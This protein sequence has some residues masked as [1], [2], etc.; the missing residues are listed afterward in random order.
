MKAKEHIGS[1][2]H[3]C[4]ADCR[5]ILPT[6][7]NESID[8]IITSPPYKK[9]DGAGPELFRPVFRECLR[10]LKNDG[11]CFVNIGH[12]REDKYSPH[13]FAMMMEML[14]WRLWENIH[15]WFK[16]DENGNQGHHTP[17]PGNSINNLH[18]Y[19]FMFYKGK[20]PELDRFHPDLGVKYADPGNTTRWKHGREYKCR[21]T[22]WP[23][24]YKTHVGSGDKHPDIFPAEVP[25]KILLLANKKNGI[26]LDPFAGCGTV[27]K[28]VATLNDKEGRKLKYYGIELFT[29][30]YDKMISRLLLTG[31][32]A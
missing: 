29:K 2:V 27:G 25:N 26:V 13:R 19:I 32:S 21:G 31:K 18:E 7:K 4:R 24:K 14:D 9:C 12:L 22:V 8:L 28:A 15:I 17:L 11:L 6:L 20:M 5:R 10:I 1:Y 30:Y 23:I 16:G 3:L